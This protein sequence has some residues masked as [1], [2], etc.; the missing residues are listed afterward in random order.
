MIYIVVGTQWGDEGKAKVVDYLGKDFDI[1][2]RYQGGVNAGHTVYYGSEKIV[3]HLIPAG[4]LREKVQAVIGNGVVIELEALV[5][6]IEMVSRFVNIEN[7]LWVSNKAHI[8]M[9]YHKLM[10]KAKEES[11]SGGIGTTLKGIGPCYGDKI[12]RLGIRVEDL[13]APGEFLIEKIKKAYEVKKFLF[14]NYY[15]MKEL[16]TVTE[17]YDGL[18]YYAEKIKDYVIDTER[19]LAEAHK[20]RMNIL[21]EGAQGGLLD[22]DFGTYP[23]VTSSNTISAGSLTG[24][25]IGCFD[26]ANVVGVTKAYITRVGGGPFPT[27]QKNATGEYLR[28]KGGEFGATTGRPRRCGWFDVVATRYSINISG[29]KEIFLTKLDVLDGLEKIYV[30]VEYEMQDGRIIDYFPPFEFLLSQVKPRYVVLDGWCEKTFGVR[31]YRDLPSNARKYIE[32]LETSL[33][34]KISYIS[35]GYNRDDVILR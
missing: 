34:K 6:E 19:F 8:V 3:F 35:T 28:E 30:C 11:D 17:I 9:P 15:H 25:G 23:F 16:P 22:I 24:S 13:F 31:N 20:N 2:V 1:V 14:E 21:F 4:I 10:D 5:K 26:I 29:V 33:G 27:E 7:R 32:F 18:M 12:E